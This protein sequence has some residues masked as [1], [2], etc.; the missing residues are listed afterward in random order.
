MKV[1]V[2][3]LRTSASLVALE[4]ISMALYPRSLSCVLNCFMPLSFCHRCTGSDSCLRL[5]RAKYSK[6]D[7]DLD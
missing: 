5:L 6:W 1:K 2:R 7:L 4:P 3:Y